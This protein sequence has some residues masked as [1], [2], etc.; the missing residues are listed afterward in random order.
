MS[1]LVT[2][3]N[4]LCHSDKLMSGLVTCLNVLCHSD[5]LMSGLVTCLS[6]EDPD[7]RKVNASH[8]CLQRWIK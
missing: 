6:D 3:L 2:C 1:G 5:K 8:T 4:V 7:V